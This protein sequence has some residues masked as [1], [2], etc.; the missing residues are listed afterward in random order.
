MFGWSTS[1]ARK[2]VSASLSGNV[3]FATLGMVQ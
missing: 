3:S 2:E 1:G